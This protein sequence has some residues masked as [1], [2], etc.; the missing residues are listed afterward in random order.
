MTLNSMAE[1]L[2][3]PEGILDVHFLFAFDYTPPK[4]PEDTKHIL[5]I[6]TF[7]ADKSEACLHRLSQIYPQAEFHYLS[8]PGVTLTSLNGN[9]ISNFH[10]HENLHRRTF[11][12]RKMENESWA[13]NPTWY[14]LGFN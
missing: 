8:K 4:A 3:I 9:K 2:Y 11:V 5:F 6:Q 13:S 12:I 1:L 14:F 7:P 10:Y